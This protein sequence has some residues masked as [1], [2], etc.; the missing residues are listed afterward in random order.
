M[1][2]VHATAIFGSGIVAPGLL[3]YGMLAPGQLTT[4]MQ[5][6]PGQL[7]TNMQL[8]P[9]LMNAGIA[10]APEMAS[11][12]TSSQISDATTSSGA[13]TISAA[14]SDVASQGEMTND[15]RVSET[16]RMIAGSPLYLHN[17][18]I[19]SGFIGASP[20]ALSQG[21]LY[22][23]SITNGIVSP[24]GLRSAGILATSGMVKTIQK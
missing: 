12:D 6:A 11:K 4:G 1:A 3:N 2:A 7:T 15:K 16:N 18:I 13:S 20:V 19:S 10:V 21:N 24:L 5:L 17:G 23:I 8:A 22:P 14:G 9:G